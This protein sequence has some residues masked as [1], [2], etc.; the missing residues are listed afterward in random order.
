[1]E[2]SKTSRGK[3]CL[4]YESY[5]YNMCKNNESRTLW[6]CKYAQRDK[7]NARATTLHNGELLKPFSVQINGLHICQQCEVSATLHV[8]TQDLKETAAQSSAPV[9]RIYREKANDLFLKNPEACKKLKPLR[10]L[11]STAY[12]ARH[13]TIPTLPKTRAEI[14]LPENY[15]QTKSGEQFLLS[16]LD[17]NNII[18][19]ATKRNLEIME[20]CETLYCDGTFDQA[21]KLFKQLYTIH[22][23]VKNKGVFPLV[24]A[25][26]YNQSRETYRL[27]LEEIKNNLTTFQ[28]KQ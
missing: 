26:L 15:Q 22:G 2:F 23:K 14:C 4:I 12:R 19:F 8:F 5:I 10:N 3:D 28:C 20:T 16:S 25:L 11:K 17:N 24:Y 6:R 13:S 1:M 7:C 9:S 18:I 27:L 21:P